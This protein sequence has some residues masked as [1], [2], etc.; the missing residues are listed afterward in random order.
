MHGAGDQ[1]LS[2]TTFAMNQNRAGGRSDGSN[3][4]LELF[5]RGARA[6]DVIEGIPGS[7]IA[8]K[9]EILLAERQLL[10]NAI[11]RQLDFVDQSRTLA[12][13]V[14]CAASLHRLDRGFV[15]VD[16][17]DQNNG[18]IRRNLMRMTQYFDAID[19][20]HLDVR[21]DDVVQGAVDFV[22]RGLTC[23]HGL[24]LVTFAPQRN[25]E[26]FANGAF[27][28]ADQYVS[29]AHL[30]RLRRRQGAP[31]PAPWDFPSFFPLE[32]AWRN[33]ADSS[34]EQELFPDTAWSGQTLC[35]RAPA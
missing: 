34:A 11:D 20:R 35:L 14:G 26:H 1:F 9:R 25:I 6:D 3:R 5:H 22:F 8:A 33:R 27:V 2:R 16:C 15:I 19:I 32:P 24:D 13:I 10:E 17:C 4:L 18:R 12:D 29:H 30:L 7:G 28:V 21:D 31:R 23:L